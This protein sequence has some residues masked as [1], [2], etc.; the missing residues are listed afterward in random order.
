MCIRDRPYVL[1]RKTLRMFED[2]T[3][4]NTLKP[5][6]SFVSNNII[7]TIKI[8]NNKVIVVFKKKMK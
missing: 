4:N 6:S 8:Q 3:I 7:S 2:E 5:N 1:R